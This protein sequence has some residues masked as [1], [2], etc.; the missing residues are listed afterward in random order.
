MVAEIGVAPVIALVEVRRRGCGGHH[1]VDRQDLQGRAGTL[2]G[3]AAA[4][5]YHTGPDGCDIGI[6]S[7]CGAAG[8]GQ[9]G[10]GLQAQ[11]TSGQIFG[12]E[13]D[14]VDFG[15]ALQQAHHITH[16]H[17]AGVQTDFKNRGQLLR[18]VV[19]IAQAA[20]RGG[21]DAHVNGGQRVG[22]DG[23]D[24]QI[25]GAAVQGD[26]ARQVH[27]LHRDLVS[28]GA[29]AQ[30]LCAGQGQAPGACAGVQRQALQGGVVHTQD[31]DAA[32]SLVAVGL[33][34]DQDEQAVG[35]GSV[36]AARQCGGGGGVADVLQHH[37][38]AHRSRFVNGHRGGA[39]G[40]TPQSGPVLLDDAQEMLTQAQLDV[41]EVVFARAVGGHLG[42]LLQV[43][44]QAVV[45]AVVVQANQGCRVGKAGE[46]QARVGARHTIGAQ[47]TGV[48]RGQEAGG[49]QLCRCVG[50]KGHHQRQRAVADVAG[51]VGG[52]EG[53]H[54]RG[55]VVSRACVLERPGGA[56]EHLRQAQ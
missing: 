55:G 20:V 56:A 13:G 48:H 36:V 22:L 47:A 25:V 19:G 52:C 28:G 43:F 1:G 10:L 53:E 29:G 40:R 41:D 44:Q 45:V 12:R 4:Q 15:A 14:A 5:A 34:V 27:G 21:G 16:L 49:P 18:D 50:V 26:V 32:S 17:G 42:N 11:P 51:F 24:H 37:G 30:G 23:R 54:P 31:G 3:A 2:L 46:G 35:V 9:L 38:G 39:A 33:A 8:S 6:H 7:A